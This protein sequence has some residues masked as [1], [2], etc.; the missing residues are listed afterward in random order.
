MTTTH[1]CLSLLHLHVSV[2][3]SQERCGVDVRFSPETLLQVL[4]PV[5]AAGACWTGGF[6]AASQTFRTRKPG[7]GAQVV[8]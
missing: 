3:S 6:E 8:C 1:L 5:A 7:A 2:S 4:G